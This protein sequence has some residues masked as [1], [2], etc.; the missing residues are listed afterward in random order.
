MKTALI[1]GE[2]WR[3][4][5]GYEEI[6]EVSSLGNVRSLDR[7]EFVSSKRTGGHFRKRKGQNLSPTEGNMGYMQ[8]ALNRGG[9]VKLCLVHR[10]IYTAFSPHKKIREI[11]HLNGI[12]R[13]NKLSNLEECSRRENALHSTRV[14][15]K[16]IGEKV[17][18]S[19][20]SEKEVLE[21]VENYSEG[22]SGVDLAIIYGVSPSTIS[23]I[24]VGKN[25]TW[26]TGIKKGGVNVS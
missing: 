3:E 18:N 16:N 24:I 19:K 14:L 12:K 9:V 10:L 5:P 20:L 8:I 26:L 6:Y 1:D 2:V 13:D 4:L 11:N 22:I 15:N 17:A 7:L 25:W 23:R 21:I